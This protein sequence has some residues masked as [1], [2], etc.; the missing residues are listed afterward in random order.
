MFWNFSERKVFFRR[1]QNGVSE[2]CSIKNVM[3][4]KGVLEGLHSKIQIFNLA[5]CILIDLERKMTN[6]KAGNIFYE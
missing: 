5:R 3:G 2:S 6:G 1:G 4:A